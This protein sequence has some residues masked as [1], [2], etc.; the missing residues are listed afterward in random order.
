MNPTQDSMGTASKTL[1][2]ASCCV[3]GSCG[4]TPWDSMI[5]PWAQQLPRTQQE[6]PPDRLFHPVAYPT[7]RIQMTTLK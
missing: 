1:L 2:T 5:A 4:L 7:L 3:R 6:T